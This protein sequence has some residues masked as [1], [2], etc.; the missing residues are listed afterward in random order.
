MTRPLVIFNSSK[1]LGSKP[2]P[3]RR[4]PKQFS[5]PAVGAPS[6][7]HAPQQQHSKQQPGQAPPTAPA[8][9]ELGCRHYA[10]CSGCTLSVGLSRPPV[11]ADAEAYFQQHGQSYQLDCGPAQHWRHRA[12]LVVQ[13]GPSGR[14]VIGL[15]KQGTHDA[16]GIPGCV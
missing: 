1:A 10:S 2:R 7:G 12:R 3:H 16:V 9:D 4:T 5:Q 8:D 6:I 15:Y 14:P 11:L 13:R